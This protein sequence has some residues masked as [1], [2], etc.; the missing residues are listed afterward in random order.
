MSVT[1]VSSVQPRIFAPAK[2]ISFSGKKVSRENVEA[3][4]EKLHTFKK[5]NE[6]IIANA[7][8][9]M[10]A[11]IKIIVLNIRPSSI[12]FLLTIQEYY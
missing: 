1:G 3:K 8:G 9:E 6:Q 10:I 2:N 11:K 12:I 4:G 7:E 5:G